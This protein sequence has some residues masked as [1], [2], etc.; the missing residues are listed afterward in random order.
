MT[1]SIITLEPIQRHGS[2]ML[3]ALY[4][5]SGSGKTL[6]AIKIAQGLVKDPKKI[7]LIDTETGRGKIYAEDAPGI[8]YAAFSPPFTP[9]RYIEVIKHVEEQGIECCIIDS[10]SHEWEGIG[11]LIEIA[12]NQKSSQGY[13]LKGLVKW[14]KPK[15]RHKKFINCMLSSQ[16]HILISLRAKEKLVQ[17]KI[18]QANGAPKDEIVSEGYVPIQERNFKFDMIVQV[19]CF[20]QEVNGMMQGGFFKLDK[21]PGKLVHAF[22]IGKQLDVDTG[23]RI[24]QWIAGGAPVDKDLEN[25]K[26]KAQE[27]ADKGTK[28]LEKLWGSLQKP[29]QIRLKPYMENFKSIAASADEEAAMAAA[30]S[31]DQSDS[32]YG[33]QVPADF[34]D[35]NQGGQQ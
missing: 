13:D 29:D 4:G 9:E 25:L 33:Q 31:D 8:M 12:D 30:V 15:A 24:A 5:M 14:S 35:Y 1:D 19:H 6:S 23:Q 18:P 11:G 28:E 17:K 21:C 26:L 7:A 20:E 3:M 10:G 2:H 27:H 32:G 34:A 16:M 22:P